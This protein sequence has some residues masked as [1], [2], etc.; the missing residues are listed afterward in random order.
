MK[1][2]LLIA[3]VILCSFL[4]SGCN[5]GVSGFTLVKGVFTGSEDE[6]EYVESSYYSE[7]DTLTA[8]N[9][10][11]E[12]NIRFERELKNYR[13]T[14]N[15]LWNSEGFY[16]NQEETISPKESL[17]DFY[18]FMEYH[19]DTQI[20]N[21]SFPT[22]IR[23]ELL[24]VEALFAEKA[25]I[26]IEDLD[27]GENYSVLKNDLVT[28]YKK[29]YREEVLNILYEGKNQLDLSVRIPNIV[30]RY[31]E[32]F[33][34][35][36]IY[37]DIKYKLNVPDSVISRGMGLN[38]VTLYSGVGDY[39]EHDVRKLAL[40]LNIEMKISG[41]S[42]K[43]DKF[44][45]VTSSIDGLGEELDGLRKDVKL[46]NTTGEL[47]WVKVRMINSIDYLDK[48]YAFYTGKNKNIELKDIFIELQVRED[49]YALG[50]L[51]DNLKEVMD[52]EDYWYELEKIKEE[53]KKENK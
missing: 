44:F 39:T 46:L 27:V 36:G 9:E 5:P 47:N 18:L 12:I 40:I 34:N 37:D 1:F 33:E 20:R 23:D 28:H 22:T 16:R 50:L 13:P 24:I 3:G 2:N 8:D 14:V 4:L 35:S 11:K 25:I 51:S 10:F 26:Y 19:K 45:H 49:F 52:N 15:E 53:I 7:D 17:I 31:N 48:I 32:V 42:M 6:S 41:A 21:L 29:M 43:L 30:D 38:V